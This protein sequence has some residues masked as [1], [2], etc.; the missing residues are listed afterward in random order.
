MT[1]SSTLRI[2]S[3]L[4]CATLAVSVFAFPANAHN[5]WINANDYSPESGETTE[6]ALR[7]GH[8]GDETLWPLISN[9]LIA[10]RAMG[11]DGITDLQS[12]ATKEPA[13]QPMPVSFS[14][15]GVYVVSVETTSSF[16][17]L[18]AEKFTSYIEDE[19]ITPIMMDRVMRGA[20]DEAGTEIYSRRGKIIINQGN[21]TEPNPTFLTKPVGLTLEIV[22][23]ANPY[24]I[25]PGDN[26]SAEIY[27]RG[28]LMPGVK[29][30]LTRLDN[31]DG[32]LAS[33]KSDE[34][35][36]VIF[37]RPDE[38]EYMLHAVWADAM[39][40]HEKADYDTIFSSLSF[41]LE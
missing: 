23:L 21:I 28:A 32:T 5:F 9:R 13:V 19:G 8:A 41:T 33:Q 26:L 40:G 3:W 38:G 24:S 27:Y 20:E 14:K 11:P 15:D 31:E 4:T 1:K 17:K 6:L 30:G 29:V 36:R 12:V 39:V 35:G 16:S 37:A 10:F 22:P 34:N 7:V 18:N 2:I 25:A